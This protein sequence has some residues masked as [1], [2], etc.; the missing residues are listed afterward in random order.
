MM[1]PEVSTPAAPAATGGTRRKGY[2][3]W[4][5]CAL[6]FFATTINY[7]D[8]QVIGI[9]APTLGKE[10]GWN[11][12]QYGNIVTCFQIAYAVGMLFAG[13]VID[14][15]G[16]RVGYALALLLWSISGMAHGL[17]HTVRGFA[18]ARFALG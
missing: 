16:T 5:I 10:I 15:L 17:V 11:E 12:K 18:T 6:L 13:P 7:V 2:Y 8:R 3:R 9:L 14:A 1:K 4:L